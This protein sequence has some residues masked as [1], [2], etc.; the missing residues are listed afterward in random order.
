MSLQ[1]RSMSKFTVTVLFALAIITAFSVWW[2]SPSQVV[3]RQTNTVIKC[4]DIPETATKTY[5]ALKTTSFSNL[6]ANRVTCHVDIAGYQ[7]DLTH[8][9]LVESHQLYAYH[10]DW[11]SAKASNIKVSIIDDQHA[12]TQADLNFTISSKKV[13]ASSE[14]IALNLSWQKNDAGKW[15]LTKVEMIGDI[16]GS[17]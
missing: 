2:F 11:A 5:R 6:L 17:M 16:V 4:L 3:K 13:A 15:Q 1:N 9:Q 8:D 7:K 10:V 12:T 14:I